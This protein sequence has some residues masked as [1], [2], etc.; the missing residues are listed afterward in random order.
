MQR[1]RAVVCRL[2]SE[3]EAG[4]GSVHGDITCATY[5]ELSSRC[6]ASV[7]ILTAVLLRTPSSE[8]IVM[9]ICRSP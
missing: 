8:L 1:P 2:I 5:G 6:T 4:G 3:A 9:S 7:P